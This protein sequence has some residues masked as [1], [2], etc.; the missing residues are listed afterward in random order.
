MNTNSDTIMDFRE[1]NDSIVKLM[2]AQRELFKT[3]DDAKPRDQFEVVES[4]VKKGD[5]GHVKQAIKAN[6]VEI[7]VCYEPDGLSLLDCA[8]RYGQVH[9]AKWLL[10]HGANPN[11][12]FEGKN[13]F[14]HAAEAAQLEA[15]RLLLDVAP[16][17]CIDGTLVYACL[18]GNLDMVKLVI[19]EGCDEEEWYHGMM[20]IHAA[21]IK[22]HVEV[23]KFLV[24]HEVD[25]TEEMMAE[26]DD[27]PLHLAAAHGQV[28]AVKYLLQLGLPVDPPNYYDE[29]PLSLATQNNMGDV[30]DVLVKHGADVEAPTGLDEETALSAAL[31]DEQGSAIA[32]LL[33]NGA[34]LSKV[35]E[36][37]RIMMCT[38]SS[39][40]VE[41]FAELVKRGYDPNARERDYDDCS[42]RPL[43]WA[44]WHNAASL[45]EAMVTQFKV[46]T[47]NLDGSNNSLLHLAVR[48][49]DPETFDVCMRVASAD[50]NDVNAGGNT[51][52]SSLLYEGI[53]V[54]RHATSSMSLDDEILYKMRKLL[55]AGADANCSCVGGCT[56]LQLAV[57]RRS[58]ECVK[59][60]LT[61]G[62]DPNAKVPRKTQT[63]LEAA[64]IANQVNLVRL[65]MSHG[66]RLGRRTAQLL[67]AAVKT[68]SREILS[69][70]LRKRMKVTIPGPSGLNPIQLAASMGAV[71][72]LSHL[73]M[74]LKRQTKD[75]IKDINLRDS[76]SRNALMYAIPHPAAVRLLI[77]NGADVNAVGGEFPV[78]T[79]T[80]AV[81]SA[82]DV[83][84]FETVKL[85]VAAGANVNDSGPH[86]GGP[87]RAAVSMGKLPLV[88][89]LLDQ[90]ADPNLKPADNSNLPIW[91]AVKRGN[92]EITKM[93]IAKGA[94]ITVTATQGRMKGW[95]LLQLAANSTPRDSNALVEVLCEAGVDVNA[96]RADGTTALHVAANAMKYAAVD[97]LLR[98]KADPMAV[99]KH[100]NTILHGYIGGARLRDARRWLHD[101]L[102]R[103]ANASNEHD[104]T[105]MWYLVFHTKHRKHRRYPEE[106]YDSDE[107]EDDKFEY[108]VS[109]TI[110][111]APSD[112]A[113][114]EVATGRIAS[115]AA[116]AVSTR[117]AESSEAKQEED[118][119]SDTTAADTQPAK[120]Q[121]V[122]PKE[123]KEKGIAS[124]TQ[125]R[126]EELVA[127][128]QTK[129]DNTASETPMADTQPGKQHCGKPTEAKEE[130]NA[131]SETDDDLS[132]VDPGYRWTYVTARAV[133]LIHYGANPTVI[134]KN[135]PLFAAAKYNVSRLIFD[136]LSAIEE[137][138]CPVYEWTA[139]QTMKACVKYG[140]YDC[141]TTIADLFLKVTWTDE[142]GCCV[143][144]WALRQ[145]QSRTFFDETFYHTRWM[146]DWADN[147]GVTPLMLAANVGLMHA[148]HLLLH[149]KANLELK[150]K[151][152]HTALHYAAFNRNANVTK[153]LLD[154]GADV[155]A[156][157]IKGKT[158]LEVMTA[159]CALRPFLARETESL[160]C[161]AAELAAEAAKKGE[162]QASAPQ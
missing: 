162:Q 97:T 125:P 31:C 59:L 62:A 112:N 156:R 84:N 129:E 15:M 29:T 124:D 102:H 58:E 85:L 78:S 12:M 49:C 77:E 6:L 89:L 60:L 16:T 48:H 63:P 28:G 26:P 132:S 86:A 135:N 73:L 153:A 2:K 88:N 81:K 13:V 66:A 34:D 92:V 105:P 1:F 161:K 126:K 120:R 114:T 95:P 11:Q 8:V 108:A 142:E 55:A 136:M 106:E 67:E 109:P 141:Y 140:A 14:H 99:N 7:N 134:V 133:T 33:R 52:L 111:P 147:Q 149:A 122:E 53:P 104:R 10:K 116:V 22:G 37:L 154:A 44:A 96:A 128:P 47:R 32:A 4:A 107:D 158:P 151:N 101:G 130:V 115:A 71:D 70:L 36:G 138:D 21:A 83:A 25:P 144:H 76:F 150:D 74:H 41:A 110:V 20:P 5:L 75:L 131:G 56:L 64:A 93:L 139:G 27:T 87:L 19:E 3:Q 69:M 50:V 35:R 24:A 152:G 91:E 123:T 159:K 137:E 160:L 18:G 113:S 65:L 117:H 98:Y 80:L 121:R 57:K 82:K 23:M 46:E 45:I 127:H 90:G 155:N 79:L 17:E 103:Y 42:K 54:L 38:A 9:I 118:T 51:P 148:V 39:G 100:G 94:D 43:A 157:N 72:V 40:S 30:I 143:W 146:K 61:H 119:A 145:R 68:G